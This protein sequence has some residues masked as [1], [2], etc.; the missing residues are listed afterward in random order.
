[1][2]RRPRLLFL[3]P[4]VPFPPDGG[5]KIRTYNILRLLSRAFDVTALCFLRHEYGNGSH[6]VDVRRRGLEPLCRL[7]TFPLPQEGSRA[8]LGW[9]HL[10]S[11]L[12]RRVYTAYLYD[13]ADF[14]AAL[15]DV[16][17]RER[18]DLVH[19][20]SL[21]LS[22]YLPELAE[23][24][25]VCTHHNVESLLLRRR[26]EREAR[27][28]RGRYLA[29]QAELMEAEERAWCGGIDLNLTVSEP[30]A[31][32]LRQIAPGARVEVVPNGVDTETFAP[33]AGVERG[34]ISVGGTNWAP[35]ADALR[36]FAA[37]VLPR[38]RAMGQDA[39][40]RWVGYAAPEEQRAFRRDHGIEL[41]GYVDDVRPYLADAA[42]FVVPLRV[43]G[44]T[45]LKIL[46][47]WAMGKAVVSTSVGCEGI[48][49]V[50]GHNLLVRDTPDGFAQAVRDVLKD[51]GLRRRLGR[52]AR[53]TVERL[54]GWDIIGAGMIET[55][56]R[57]A[58]ERGSGK[59]RER[60]V[61][62]V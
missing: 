9:D 17:A 19:M 37:D 7:S 58:G 53:Q 35:N 5:A 32:V 55:Y 14:R 34:V 52:A 13:S 8:R 18:F 3:A 27:A 47:A 46:D 16:L 57:L 45:R 50:D 28:W 31:Q 29:H 38:L 15:R 43:G 23:L 56:L 44:G 51:A 1:M 33:A 60:R 41:T 59:A 4:N 20:D 24:P 10:R 49:A 62:V 39:P 54:Y 61:H 48:Q 22:G 26:A 36:Y 6:G 21:D 11:L 40:V 12:R 25:V 42:C 30:D 2:S